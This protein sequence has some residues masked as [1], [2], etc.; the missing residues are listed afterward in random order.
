MGPLRMHDNAP[1]DSN[2]ASWDFPARSM[3]ASVS[4]AGPKSGHSL[5]TSNILWWLAATSQP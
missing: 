3:R 1:A 4:P 2:D 5:V